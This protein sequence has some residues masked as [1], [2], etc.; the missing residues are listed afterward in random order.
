MIPLHG[1]KLLV[2]QESLVPIGETRWLFLV[3]WRALQMRTRHV[4]NARRIRLSVI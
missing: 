1:R 4:V 2:A 3:S